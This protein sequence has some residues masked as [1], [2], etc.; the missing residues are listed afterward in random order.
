[1]SG[2]RRSRRR[3]IHGGHEEEGEAR[4]V[5]LDPAAVAL[6]DRL[7]DR[8]AEAGALAAAP[9]RARSARRRARGR[10]RARAFVLRRAMNASPSVA[11]DGR[12]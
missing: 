3:A 1:M 4:A 7:D 10:S 9:G 8:Q 5:D 2:Q 11:A 6:G 12:R